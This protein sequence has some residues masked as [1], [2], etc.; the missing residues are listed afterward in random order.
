MKKLFLILLVVFSYSNIFAQTDSQT[1]LKQ[2]I[3]SYKSGNLDSAIFLAEKSIEAADKQQSKNLAQKALA[4][5]VSATLHTEKMKKLSRK[6][7][8]NLTKTNFSKDGCK[9]ERQEKPPK[10]DTEKQ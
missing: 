10:K 8:R 5:G 2:S 6:S 4:L 3:D 1:L 7:Q 9:L